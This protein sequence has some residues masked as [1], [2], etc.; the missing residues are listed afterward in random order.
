MQIKSSIDIKATPQKVWEIIIDIENAADRIS[1]IEKVEILNRPE[2]GLIGLKWKETRV[3]F[4]KEAD[5]TMEI[6]ASEAPKYYETHAENHG[7]IYTSK[8]EVTSNDSGA[9]LTMSFKGEPQTFGAK[10]MSFLMT[11]LFKGATK[12]MVQKDLE[13]IKAFAEGQ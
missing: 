4:G 10:L 2:K 11:P 9:T 7:A 5:E 12:K 1:G 8:L 13:E 3:M 6:V